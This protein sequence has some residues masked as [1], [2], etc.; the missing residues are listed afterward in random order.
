MTTA[1]IISELARVTRS[2]ATTLYPWHGQLYEFESGHPMRPL[3][4]AV[5]RAGGGVTANIDPYAQYT[6]AGAGDIAARFGAKLMLAWA[7]IVPQGNN[8]GDPLDEGLVRANLGILADRLAVAKSVL[9]PNVERVDCITVDIESYNCKDKPEIYL[10]AVD[11]IYNRAYVVCKSSFPGAYVN[12]WQRGQPGKSFTSG[13]ERGDGLHITLAQGPDLQAQTS[14]L[15]SVQVSSPRNTVVM[16]WVGV[17]YGYRPE[18]GRDSTLGYWDYPV[19]F[20]H[21]LGAALRAGNCPRIATLNALPPVEEQ[22][23]WWRH[24]TA[25]V[26]GLAGLNAEPNLT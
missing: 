22:P 7:W 6:V 1:S 3:I 23:G 9:G 2:N 12:F 13:R 26:F 17:G 20:S 25:F 14:L 15:G 11:A 16:P 19:A 8:R 10:A 18:I 21:R 4:E 5:A 24:F